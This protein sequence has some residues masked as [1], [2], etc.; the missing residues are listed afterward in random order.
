MPGKQPYLICNA[1]KKAFTLQLKCMEAD[2][3]KWKGH[4][5]GN[6]DWNMNTQFQPPT[7]WILCMS[8][9]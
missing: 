7:F 5:M 9:V 8:E 6:I 1:N 3:W 2:E 4:S